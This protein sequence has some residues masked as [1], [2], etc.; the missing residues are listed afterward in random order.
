[1]SCEEGSDEADQDRC[2]KSP[3]ELDAFLAELR[4]SPVQLCDCLI[5]VMLSRLSGCFE[6]GMK[7][8]MMSKS[9]GNKSTCH[10]TR[11][12]IAFRTRVTGLRRLTMKLKCEIQ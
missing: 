2:R 3:V 11:I 1:V 7:F 12:E 8:E 6:E 10:Y 9:K 5:M 4:V